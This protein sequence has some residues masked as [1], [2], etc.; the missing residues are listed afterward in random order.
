[1]KVRLPKG[2]H[3]ISTLLFIS[4]YCLSCRLHSQPTISFTPII[5]GLSSPV[6]IVNAG[7][8]SNRIFV[9]EQGGTIKVFS[10][11]YTLLGTFLTVTG[12]TTG[13]ERGL[14]SLAFHPDYET[15][16]FFWVYYTNVNGDVEVSRYK[17][18]TGNAN[19]ADAAS[20]QVL[21]TITHPTYA[22]HNG[23]KLNFGK[24]GYLYFGT[25]DGG[26]GGDPNN[27][28]QNGNSLLG[29]MLRINVST[30]ATASFYTIPPDN[31]FVNDA[32]VLDE[33]WA[34]GLRNPFR[35]SFDRSN[36][37]MWIGDVGQDTREEID[38][39]SAANSAGTNYGWRCYEGNNA[40]NTTG[41]AAASN[42]VFPVYD[43]VNP[44][45]GSASVIGGFVYRGTTYPDMQGYYYASDVYSGN[46]YKI[47]ISNFTTT[48]Q[49]GVPTLI[50]GYGETE[51]AELLCVSLNGSAYSVQ[52]TVTA[53]PG[54]N[55]N[56]NK[57]V[58]YPTIINQSTFLVSLPSVYEQL[59]IISING[60]IILQQSIRG[61][62]GT[63]EI[64]LPDV[65]AGV[66]LVRLTGKQKFF[67]GKI[68]VTR[69]S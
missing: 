24:D 21:I 33:I 4:I 64:K 61:R 51:N 69:Q 13:G 54:V 67:T 23:G 60:I 19:V 43:Y 59:Q 41:C 32:N 40:Y 44:S 15:N 26:S 8:G 45:S 66:Y 5:T 55:S 9:V 2:C 18:S 68:I 63:V 28:A 25:G 12:I 31:P 29:K 52:S 53:I 14:L 1:M 38:Y 17:V 36:G 56:N 42:Y 27:N 47:N 10:S 57:P 34:L 48:V 3:K 35:W 58:I 37:D 49:S 22:N 46:L 11:S 7:D 20:K 6:D 39:R 65:S 16:G 50:A 62:T 30:S